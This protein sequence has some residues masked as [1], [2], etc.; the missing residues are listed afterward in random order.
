[1][2]KLFVSQAMRGKTDEEILEK[3]KALIEEAKAIALEPMEPLDTFFDFNG[4]PLEHLGSSISMLSKAYI[5]IFGNGW[6]ETR[7]CVIE[8]MCCV[9]YGIPII[10]ERIVRE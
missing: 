4:S 10:Y 6:Q 7:G 8:H 3:R 1:M 5:A 2:L 9:H